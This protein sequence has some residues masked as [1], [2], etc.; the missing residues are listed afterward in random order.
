MVTQADLIPYYYL[1]QQQEQWAWQQGYLAGQQLANAIALL[2]QHR[3]QVRELSE[4]R[5]YENAQA[6]SARRLNNAE[7]NWAVNRLLDR[8]GKPHPKG[9]VWYDRRSDTYNWISPGSGR[10]RSEPA[11][12]FLSEVG[13][14]L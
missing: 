5:A 7:A 9:G 6:I 1:R 10:L 3:A 11:D 8:I 2:A 13:P 12:E 4:A 14:Y